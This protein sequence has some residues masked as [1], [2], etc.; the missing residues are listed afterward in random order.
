M[1]RESYWGR[2]AEKRLN[3]RRALAAASAAGATVALAACG[4][5][6]GSTSSGAS[7]QSAGVAP[8]Q[9]GTLTA[10][11]LTDP[12]DFDPT[13]KPTNNRSPVSQCYDSLLSF[14]ATPDN[15]YNNVVLMPGLAEQ[16]EAPD[17]LTFTFH[18]R[19]G[20]RFHNLP[21]VNGREVTSEDLKWSMQY[22][23][24]TGQFKD[25]KKLFPALY[26]D[27]FQS[28]ADIQTPDA[29]T[30]VY[31]FSDPLAP[32]INY[33]AAEW[34]PVLAHEVYDAEGN[35]SNTLIG[36]G[37][38]FRDA[39]SS[40]NGQKT[41]YRRNP[42]YFLNGIPY[43]DQVN[44]IDLKDD[45]TALAALQTKQL[46]IIESRTVTGVGGPDVIKRT[47]PDA[48]IFTDLMKSKLISL[49]L[50]KPPLNDLRIRQALSLSI[51]RDEFIKTMTGGKGQ[52]ALA[53]ATPGLFTDA[54]IKQI[55][56]YDPD[57][58]KQLVADAGYPSGVD[59]ELIY[60]TQ[61]YGQEH[62]TQVQLLQAQAKKGN[63]NIKLTPLEDSTESK[64]QK[65]GDFQIDVLPSTVKAGDLDGIIFA[66][67]YSTSG[68]NYG[69][70]RDPK[71]DQLLIAQ[72]REMDATKRR[73][74]I[75]QAVRY[76]NEQV[77]GLGMYDAPEYWPWQP[78]VKNFALN[79]A[80]LNQHY[81]NTWLAK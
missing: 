55:L 68:S 54:E 53:S 6:G 57:Q 39:G 44:E 41:V 51:D 77:Y 64:R 47:I 30:V 69:H 38:F 11:Q 3:R 46:D 31:K 14:K 37:P 2:Q 23:S 81:L 66:L 59:I 80:Q 35:F 58:A 73:D 42:N 5:G 15:P 60:P 19:K 17:G 18:L 43:L 34:N 28:L 52:W 4:R 7:G 78:Y 1:A 22:I 70:V 48:V 49:G 25:D 72:R 16:W 76:L 79:V 74:L 21:P 13:G 33:C 40:A 56:K 45:S 8:R 20:I 67:Y 36:T 10:R 27:S 12:F 63:I 26:S 71:L 32:F 75:R 65:E 24:R 29:Q 50:D 61:K 9:G 62:I